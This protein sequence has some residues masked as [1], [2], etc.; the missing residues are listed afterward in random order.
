MAH[1][2]IEIREGD[3][4]DRASL[5]HGTGDGEDVGGRRLPRQRP[6]RGGLNDRAIADR[7]RERNAELD[8]I[9]PGCLQR[10]DDPNGRFTIGVTAGDVGNQAGAA[11]TSKVAEQ[12]LDAIHCG[13]S[14]IFMTCG[15]SLSPRPL[16]L[17]TTI[18]SL[19]M[20]SRPWRKSQPSACADSSAGMMPSVSLEAFHKLSETEGIIQEPAERV[21]RLERGNDAL[22]LAQLVEGLERQ[23]VAA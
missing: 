16:R 22:G 6:M 8:R 2:R 17:T 18:A 1:G 21:R 14:S 20:V 12:P 15:T 7:V 13:G 5:P 23:R 10:L 19:A 4:R 11:V 3:E 9:G